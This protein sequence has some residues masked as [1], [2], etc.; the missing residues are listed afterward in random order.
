MVRLNE[1]RSH[2]ELAFDNEEERQE[3]IRVLRD[4]Q[5]ILLSY[6]YGLTTSSHYEDEYTLVVEVYSTT[7]G[8]NKVISLI[9]EHIK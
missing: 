3:F 8:Y 6:D 4:C 5:D 7:R 1:V 9:N 2:Y